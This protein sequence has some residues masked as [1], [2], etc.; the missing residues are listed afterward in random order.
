M[1]IRDGI[2]SFRPPFTV[3]FINLHLNSW[4]RRS[5]RLSL[6]CKILPAHSDVIWNYWDHSFSKNRRHFT[7]AAILSLTS[8]ACHG[9]I[10]SGIVS[11]LLMLQHCWW[12]ANR[13]KISRWTDSLRNGLYF[14]FH[15]KKEAVE[16]PRWHTKQKN[17]SSTWLILKLVFLIVLPVTFKLKL[18][19]GWQFLSHLTCLSLINAMSFSKVKGWYLGCEVILSISKTTPLVFSSSLNIK[20]VISCVQ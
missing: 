15:P 11:H 13:E 16:S 2:Y 10:F 14:L 5:L 6:Y 7:Q 9:D 3:S 12:Q 8:P 18:K 19:L 1:K 20:F 4:F 17:K